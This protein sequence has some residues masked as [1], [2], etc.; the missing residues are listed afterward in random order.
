MESWMDEE[1]DNLGH[2]SFYLLP[3][4]RP[5][6]SC[7]LEPEPKDQR[8]KGKTSS[9]FSI[10]SIRLSGERSGSGGLKLTSVSWIEEKEILRIIYRILAIFI[11]LCTN[12]VWCSS[13]VYSQ[14]NSVASVF[15]SARLEPRKAFHRPDTGH[16]PLESDWGSMD[17]VWHAAAMWP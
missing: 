10:S 7:R 17:C 5:T 11:T 3:G 6:P 15:S 2:G 14:N 4:N 13:S 12:H 1:F 8:G 9:D 16:A